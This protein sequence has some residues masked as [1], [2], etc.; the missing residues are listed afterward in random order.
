MHKKEK[1]LKDFNPRP[2][3]QIKNEK[4]FGNDELYLYYST[5][6]IWLAIE[7]EI[8]DKAMWKWMQNIVNTTATFTDYT[9]MQQTLKKAISNDKKYEQVKA[10]YLES[11]N[12]LKNAF[13]TIG[14][15]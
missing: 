15:P 11:D 7:K 2:L 13:L 6:V 9:F 3:S 5:P 1:I 14:T 10:K 4:D 8:G 12:A